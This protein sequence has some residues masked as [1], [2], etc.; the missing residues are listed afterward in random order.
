MKQWF[1]LA[2]LAAL[3][4][5]SSLPSEGPRA[6]AVQGQ[7]TKKAGPEGSYALVD[8]DYAAVYRMSNVKPAQFSTLA[9]ATSVAPIDRIG[10]G[11][12]L[13]V[14][15][16]EPGGIGLFNSGRTFS[17]GAS[18]ETLPRVGV[19]E[20]GAVSIPFGG[21]VKVAG[22]TPVQAGAVIAQALKGKAVDPQV[23]VT[24]VQ[25]LANA[26]TVIGEVRQAGRVPLSSNGDRLLDVIAAAGG[27]TRPNADVVVAVVRSGQ[28]VESV[29]SDVLADASQNIR[30]APRD[31]VRLL[32]RPRMYSTFGAFQRSAQIPIET[33]KVTLAGAISR[34]GGLVDQ[35]ANASEVLIFR[36]ERVDVARELGVN[37]TP[38]Y[39]GVPVVYR[40]NLREPQSFFTAN[41]FEIRSDDLLYVPNSDVTE[42]RK[43]FEF[44]QSVTRVVYDVRVTSLVG[45]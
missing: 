43:F 7:A 4:G 31:Q 13:A 12:T 22:L 32:H 33:D 29:L 14:S 2:A 17:A 15:I 19:D 24:V 39:K 42:L 25:N 41:A 23:V 44:V 36:F 35:R 30:L 8:L 16:F 1:A 9:P 3:V 37:A 18:T 26:V 10:P 40:L 20:D 28:E 6:G 45:N 34:S 21:R 27:A 5:C 38:T 11:D